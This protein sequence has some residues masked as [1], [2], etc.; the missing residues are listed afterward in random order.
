MTKEI[1]KAIP[2]E[3]G[4]EV[5]NLGRVRSVDRAVET[6]NGQ[7][8]RY[9]GK[10]LSPGL[11]VGYPSVSCG[12][13]NSRHVHVLVLEAF[14]GPRPAGYEARHLNRN[15]LDPRESNLSWG[16][17]SENN[18]DRTTHGQNLL[19]R[20]QVQEA[21]GLH[22]AGKTGLELA[23]IYGVSKST[24]YYALSGKLYG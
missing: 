16:P 24:M 12:L 18:R 2:S 17:R 22:R 5:S 11:S 20:D 10:V 1:W 7:T 8:R 3:P 13:G 21:R 14:V 6:Q 4:Y 19:T 9:S 23:S 15:K